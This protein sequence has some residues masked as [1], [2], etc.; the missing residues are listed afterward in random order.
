MSMGGISKQVMA[1]VDDYIAQYPQPVQETLL[2]LREDIRSEIADALAA[3]GEQPPV[4]EA[5]RY[6]IPTFIL[7]GNLVHF[8]AYPRHIGLYPGAE[9][10]EHFRPQLTEYHTSTG[11][12]Q[13][14][15]DAPLPMDLIRAIVRFCVDRNMKKALTKSSKSPHG[16]Q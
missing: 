16:K 8:A 14:P 5:I 12:V 3:Y 4:S 2:R 13:F 11:T 6:G 10:M 7:Y 9:A 15:L 1:S